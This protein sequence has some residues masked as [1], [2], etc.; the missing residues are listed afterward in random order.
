VKEMFTSPL[1]ASRADGAPRIAPGAT[2]LDANDVVDVVLLPLGVTV[3]VYETPFVR[4][5][6]TQLYV[7]SA[8]NEPVTVQLWVPPTALMVYV[9]AV[10]SA[11]NATLT[12]PLPAFVAIG[13]AS[14]LE[15]TRFVEGET[16]VVSEVV[17]TVMLVFGNVCA[18]EGLM[19]P[20]MVSVAAVLAAIAQAFVAKVITSVDPLDVLVA[21][22]VVAPVPLVIEIAGFDVAYVKPVGKATVIVLAC[23][24]EIAP[25]DDVVNPTV[26]GDVWLG[27]L[28]P[29]VN[30]TALG[31]V[32]VNVKPAAAAV[33]PSITA[34]TALFVVT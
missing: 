8:E 19:I 3:K 15:M 9:V 13:A 28:E 17:A 27:R 6:T 30:V 18:T 16:A 32:A 31:D 11:V 14:W 22:Q 1:P 7:L 12:S 4:L 24:R 33:G 29:G 20:A 10:P 34:G 26:I 21:V 2:A 5:L 25:V 23:A